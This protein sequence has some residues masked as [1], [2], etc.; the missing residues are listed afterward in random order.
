[1]GKTSITERVLGGSLRVDRE[2]G[3]IHGVRILGLE[4]RNR[5]RYLPEAI[6]RA[7]ALYEGAK[8]YFDHPPKERIGSVRGIKEQAGWL[9]SVTIDADGG[10]R[11]NFHYF[12]SDPLTAKIAEAAERRPDQ[13]GFSHNI[14]GV[15]EHRGGQTVVTEIT[16]VR[17]VDLVTDPATTHGLFEGRGGDGMP[18]N[19]EE[20]ARW[21]EAVDDAPSHD[22]YNDQTAR[23]WCE[24]RILLVFNSSDTLEGKLARIEKVLLHQESLVGRAPADDS[25]GPATEFPEDE[26]GTDPL[27]AEPMRP[28]FEKLLLDVVR[29]DKT[30]PA[31]MD[32]IKRILTAKAERSADVTNQVLKDL[33][34]DAGSGPAFESRQRG[35]SLPKTGSELA[36][37]LR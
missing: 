13:F 30:V 20:L 2:A 24:E 21:L 36:A 4:S 29:S 23:A 11:G 14:D 26:G 18:T 35:G 22:K 12:K 10:L 19:G 31:K 28:K 16:D 9:Q 27:G 37:W 3:I 34:I 17:S 5:R 7:R 1:M 32:L 6:K 8:V 25:P 33:G 15:T